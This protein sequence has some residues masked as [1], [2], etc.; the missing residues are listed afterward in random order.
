MSE[1]ASAAAELRAL[2]QIARPLSNPGG[3]REKEPILNR[4]THSIAKRLTTGALA[5]LLLCQPA[6]AAGNPQVAANYH[7]PFSDVAENHWFYPY[8]AALSAQGVVSGNDDGTF[9]PN[10][11][12]TLGAALVMVLKAAGCGTMEPEEGAHYASAYAAYAAQKNWL[13]E[14]QLQ[15]LDGEITRQLVAQLAAQ[16]MGFTPSSK[17]SPF[18]DVN[19]GYVTVLYENGVLSGSTDETGKLVFKPLDSITR[20][21]ISAIVWQI[22]EYANHIHFQGHSVDILENVA[23]FSYDRSK[24]E[25]NGT[26]MT[27]TGDDAETALGVDVSVHQGTVNWQAVKEDGIDFAMIRVGGRGYGSGALYDDANFEA[28]IQGALQAGLEVGV[29]FFSQALNAQEAQEEADYVLSKIQGYDIT[30]PVV[31]DWERIGTSSAR[32][33]NM[34]SEALSEA[35]LAFCQRIQENGYQAMVYF[36]PY[37]GYLLYQLDDIDDYPFWVAQYTAQPTFYYDFQIWQYTNRGQVNGINGNVD[38][39]LSLKRW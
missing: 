3:N 30:Y 21:E 1:Y 9:G 24:F 22:Q 35:A 19:D 20:A 6:F 33:D 10:Q 11:K 16:A 8:V 34:T 39:D 23:P 31:F 2:Y 25:L 32:T 28:N 26:R 7:A 17:P 12:T 18:A 38:M 36:Y 13:K 27:Y 4:Q 15:D 29:Y 5:A 14:D 37:I